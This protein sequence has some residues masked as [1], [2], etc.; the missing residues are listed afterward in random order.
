MRQELVRQVQ[1]AT[2]VQSVLECT[3]R[4]VR[5]AQRPVLG[6]GRFG[7]WGVSTGRL[8]AHRSR[9]P[10]LDGR[11]PPEWMVTVV[12]VSEWIHTTTTTIATTFHHDRWISGR[13]ART[14]TSCWAKSTNKSSPSHPPYTIQMKELLHVYSN[15]SHWFGPFGTCTLSH[16]V[17][18]APYTL[19]SLSTFQTNESMTECMH[20]SIN[21]NLKK[22]PP[23]LCFP[24]EHC[25][26]TS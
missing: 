10:H 13:L 26:P 22:D 2:T 9:P 24:L 1:W 5:P 3:V 23:I 4:R 15:I 19:H 7:G 21:F 25:S 12:V 11:S 20:S 14:H 17:T 16:S 6:C 18:S 8:F